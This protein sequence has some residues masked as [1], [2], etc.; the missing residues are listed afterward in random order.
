M[1]F[2][3]E[4]DD[5]DDDGE[6]YKMDNPEPAK[7]VSMPKSADH[8]TFLATVPGFGAIRHEMKGSWFIQ[9]FCKIIQEK[10]KR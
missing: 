5:D 4:V 10:Y 7:E 3:F 6:S 2:L 8:L 9:T 1:I